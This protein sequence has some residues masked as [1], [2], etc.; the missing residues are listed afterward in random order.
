MIRR[1]SFD[2]SETP[3]DHSPPSPF[4][5]LEES[6]TDLRALTSSSSPFPPSPNRTGRDPNWDQLQQTDQQVSGFLRS[7]HRRRIGTG[8]MQYDEDNFRLLPCSELFNSPTLQRVTTIRNDDASLTAVKGGFIDLLEKIVQLISAQKTL[9]PKKQKQLS[10]KI[11]QLQVIV[12]GIARVG[13]QRLCENYRSSNEDISDIGGLINLGNDCFQLIEKPNADTLPCDVTANLIRYNLDPYNLIRSWRKNQKRLR[14]IKFSID[15]GVILTNGLLAMIANHLRL[16]KFNSSEKHAIRIAAKYI[17]LANSATNIPT[18]GGKWKPL[19]IEQH[20]DGTFYYGRGITGITERDKQGRSFGIC[21][22]FYQRNQ[23]HNLI[24]FGAGA[25]DTEKKKLQFAY[26]IEDMARTHTNIQ[27]L[28]FHSLYSNVNEKR[29]MQRVRHQIIALGEILQERLGFEAVHINTAFNATTIANRV[30]LVEFIPLIQEDHRSLRKINSRGLAQLAQFISDDFITIS[31]RQQMLDQGLP[32]IKSDSGMRN[33]AELTKLSQQCFEAAQAIKKQAS[34]PKTDFS[35]LSSSNEQTPSP[36][37]PSSS[38]N[39]ALNTPERSTKKGTETLITEQR[40]KLLNLLRQ[41]IPTI[42]VITQELD[43]EL[44]VSS[45]RHLHGFA[46]YS[47]ILK[48]FEIILVRQLKVADAPPLSRCSEIE[49]FLLVYRLLNCITIITCWSG[50]DRSGDIRA[51]SDA[52]TQMEKMFFNQFMADETQSEEACRLKATQKVFDLILKLD[53]NQI[54]LIRLTQDFIREENINPIIDLKNWQAAPPAEDQE[55]LPTGMDWRAK[56][57]LKITAQYPKEDQD[58]RWTLYYLEMVSN[59]IIS[60][61]GEKILMSA[62]VPGAQYHFLTM[63]EN[64]H[65]KRRLAPFFITEDGEVIQV[66]CLTQSRLGKETITVTQA[67]CSII[68][69]LSTLRS[70]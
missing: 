56:F 52:L 55:Q 24:F 43:N 29:L 13:F 18:V 60:S 70:T 41:I 40:K 22:L 50:L 53:E 14:E 20:A 62:G 12:S 32:P 48:I 59:N 7:L 51:M 4:P 28:V 2:G 45:Q 37:L 58:L 66:L 64:P 57:L 30:P 6:H 31:N 65:P 47:L 1:H 16:P 8:L 10:K 11:S 21:S 3:F 68:Q 46:K 9:S 54:K 61:E 63:V 36:T 25:I 34:L 15:K 27:R 69:Q 23:F 38:S 17:R 5:H 19:R 39:S 44:E 49:L 42:P 67:G 33:H 26:V 35:Q